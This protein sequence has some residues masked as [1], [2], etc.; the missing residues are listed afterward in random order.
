MTRCAR[1][2]TPF[3]LAEVIAP[4]Q[5]VIT[6]SEGQWDATLA[7]AYADGWILLELDDTER[8]IRAY[9]KRNHEARP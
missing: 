4:G 7:A 3:P 6:M 2:L 5:P 8:P 9:R 1:D